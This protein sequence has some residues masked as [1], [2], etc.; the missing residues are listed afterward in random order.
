MTAAIWVRFTGLPHKFP[1]KSWRIPDHTGSFVS[2]PP[3]TPYIIIFE[4]EA[5]F[6]NQLGSKRRRTLSL[7]QTR[8]WGHNGDDDCQAIYAQAQT[9]DADPTKVFCLRMILNAKHSTSDDSSASFQVYDKLV[10]DA[11]FHSNHLRGLEGVHVP[12]HYGMWIMDTG[13]WAGTVLFSLTQWCGTSWNELQY[14]TLNTEANRI[15]VGRSYE[16]LHDFGIFC[17]GLDR[18]HDFRH[19]IFDVYAPGLTPAQRLNGEAPCYIVDFSEARADHSCKRT[20]PVL[21]LDSILS[22]NVVGCREMTD[23]LFLLKFMPP[24]KPTK[25]L[26][27]VVAWHSEYSKRHPDQPGWQVRA[28]QRAKLYPDMPPVHPQ[29]KLA[30]ADDSP[31]ARATFT[32]ESAAYSDDEDETTDMSDAIDG[33]RAESASSE[34]IPDPVTTEFR[35]SKLEALLC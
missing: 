14:T 35:L 3:N 34:P 32:D 1:A 22:V 18:V 2:L 13:D 10:R 6:A 5:I 12:L 4:D 15:L 29:Y 28:A 30:F 31:Y 11:E 27:E 20:V 16:A 9:P 7:D 8:T 26:L 23:A 19:V 17:G 25:Q 33:F 24:I 21:P